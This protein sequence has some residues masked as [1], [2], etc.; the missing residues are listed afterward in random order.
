MTTKLVTSSQLRDIAASKV[1]C[2]G[3]F[4]ILHVGHIRYFEESKKHGDIL[5]VSLTADKYVNKGPGRPYFKLS[6]RLQQIAALEIVDYV[7]ISNDISACEIIESIRPNK[8][9]KGVE[10]KDKDVAGNLARESESLIKI[11]GDLVFIDTPKNSS[12]ELFFSNFTNNNSG[13]LALNNLRE[14][15][16]LDY[17]N[18]VLEK[19]KKLKIC[20][21]GELII[22]TYVSCWVENVSSKSPS[23]SG[24]YINSEKYLGGVGV[25]LEIL[26][27]LGI[28]V[29]GVSHWSEKQ[30]VILK[31]N[32]TLS[33]ANMINIFEKNIN[34]PEKIRYIHDDNSQRIF[35]LIKI[36]NLPEN[37]E[38]NH[39]LFK[40]AQ[41]KSDLILIYDFGHGFIGDIMRSQI[42]IGDKVW[43]NAQ[44]NSDN[45]G[46]N[47]IDKYIGFENIV[48]DRREASLVVSKKGLKNEDLYN[49]T[50]KKLGLKN[51]CL[52]LG[53]EGCMYQNLSS[54]PALT[55]IAKDA[56]GAGDAFYLIYALFTHVTKDKYFSAGLASIFAAEKVKITGHNAKENVANFKKAI[57]SIFK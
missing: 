10:Y 21:I 4:D 38:F 55:S 3:V 23:L 41:D 19:F 27:E 30:E 34:A 25:V 18:N 45:Y 44:T 49:L 53:K 46:Y 26:L 11:G 35:E 29:I 8:Y 54:F 37:L 9:C 52:T 33:D 20:V 12:T 1:L 31:I 47:L 16:S 15:Y 32:G 7:I 13:A 2:H 39:E 22:D 28:D 50:T 40:N 57:Q 48:I 24:R 5:I 51:L 36:E 43:V 17:V 56:T 42:T 14:I 6:E